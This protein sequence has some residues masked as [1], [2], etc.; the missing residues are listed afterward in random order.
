M[1]RCS[2]IVFLIFVFNNSQRNLYLSDIKK[3]K[4]PK[5]SFF[6]YVKFE[7]FV[8]DELLLLYKTAL[9]VIKT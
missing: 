8:T 2:F 4:K 9:I 5:V 7:K 1:M 3:K 6:D